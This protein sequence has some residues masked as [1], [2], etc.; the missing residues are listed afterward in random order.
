MGIDVEIRSQDLPTF[1]RRVYTDYDF[2]CTSLFYGAFA[3][4]TQGVQRLYWSKSIQ[5]GV[6]YTNPGEYR[7]AQ[8]DRIIE[9]AQN[10]N[11]PAKRKVLYRDM[12]VLAMTDMPIVPLMETRFATIASTR[13]KDHT[14][15][16]DGI[17]GS[18]FADAKFE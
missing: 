2:D 4:P 1:F 11:D 17:I 12:Q 10:E 9:A 7:S 3:D 14:T 16:A 5:K 13:L 6:V 18:N 15:T 8:M